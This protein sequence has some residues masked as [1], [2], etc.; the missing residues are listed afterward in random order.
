MNEPESIDSID[1]DPFLQIR[2]AAAHHGIAFAH[3]LRPASN[4][5]SGPGN[6]NQAPPPVAR[7]PGST[8][9]GEPS[10]AQRAMNLFRAVMPL[11][12]RLLPLLEGNVLTAISN[13][14]T[15]RPQAP[16]PRT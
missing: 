12:Q 2:A 13:V 14:L 7:F 9:G 11:V 6:R 8:S 5:L 15:P 16:P 4:G 3:G 1:R 10:G